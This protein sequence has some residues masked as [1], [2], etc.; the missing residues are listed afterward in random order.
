MRPV[1]F[2]LTVAAMFVVSS[3]LS[4]AEDWSCFPAANGAGI[5]ELQTIPGEAGPEKNVIWK[6]DVAAGISSPGEIER[7]TTVTNQNRKKEKA[8]PRRRPLEGK[9]SGPTYIVRSANR[10]HGHVRLATAEM[11]CSVRFRSSARR[12]ANSSATATLIMSVSLCIS[13]PVSFAEDPVLRAAFI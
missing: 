2:T 7:A 10:N 4:I 8:R 12:G 6:I 5:A 1:L 11:L 3:S 13:M 9:F